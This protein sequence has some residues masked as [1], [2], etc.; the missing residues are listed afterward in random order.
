VKL[1]TV[2]QRRE[3]VR[4]GTSD[5]RPVDVRVLAATNRDVRAQVE[6][7]DFREDLY[8]RLAVVPLEI[9][10][11]RERRE[12]IPDL[13]GGLVRFFRDMLPGCRVERVSKEALAAL[14]DH[15]WPG[16]VRELINAVE[17]GM[18]LS[19]GEEL[20][21]SALPPEVSGA[22]AGALAPAGVAVDLSSTLKEVREAAVAAAEREYLDRLLAANEGRINDSAQQAGIS[23]RAL[24]DRLKRYGIDKD[25][26]R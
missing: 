12:D 23:T 22:A 24:Y 19:R 2:L 10:A 26:Y 1:L 16:N 21:L 6:R 15:E 7:G 3:V 5:P 11:L 8:Y 14:V 20:E 18:L 4:L 13:V 17:R 9:P 25:D